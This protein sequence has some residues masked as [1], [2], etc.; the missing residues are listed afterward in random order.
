MKLYDVKV[1]MYLNPTLVKVA[2]DVG[3][4]YCPSFENRILLRGEDLL[5]LVNESI[6]TGSTILR[7]FTREK[8]NILEIIYDTKLYE[9]KISVQYVPK[10]N[11]EFVLNAFTI[12]EDEAIRND[13]TFAKYV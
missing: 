3:T 7:F 6:K 1:L 13:E 2:P 11:I 12:I 9:K 4:I 8:S 5:I 10:E